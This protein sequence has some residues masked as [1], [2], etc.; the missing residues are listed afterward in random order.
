MIRPANPFRGVS[1]NS[2]LMGQ[3]FSLREP[4]KRLRSQVYAKLIPLRL[5]SIA[6][7]GFELDR[8]LF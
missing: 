2:Q 4:L 7:P 8:P 3:L 5:C 1:C 6:Q